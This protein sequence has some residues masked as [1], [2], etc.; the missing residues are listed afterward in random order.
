MFASVFLMCKSHNKNTQPQF[1]NS[2]KQT[3]KCFL[4]GTGSCL[5][6]IQAA[7]THLLL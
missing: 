2:F 7:L 4:T 5:D 3:Y 1:K 6:Y